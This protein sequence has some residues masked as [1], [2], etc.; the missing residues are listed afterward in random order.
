MKM[1]APVLVACI[2]VVIACM[3]PSHAD[4]CPC[5]DVNTNR[6]DGPPCY[7]VLTG[8]NVPVTTPKWYPGVNNTG[9]WAYTWNW[10][11]SFNCPWVQST[12]SQC[13]VCSRIETDLFQT[14]QWINRGTIWS[15]EATGSCNAS[16]VTTFAT[17]FPVQS[18][19]FTGQQW[20]L[21][22]QFAVFNPQDSATCVGQVYDD[23]VTQTFTVPAPPYNGG[24]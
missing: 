14:N 9:T 3:V 19:L 11:I 20:Q 18:T 1:L 7:A 4:P 13:G 17:T 16:Y 24:Q 22:W 8:W 6:K 12:H 2:L 23:Y 15:P 5:Q 21:T 10:T